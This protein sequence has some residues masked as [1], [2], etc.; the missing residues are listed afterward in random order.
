[1]SGPVSSDE[2]VE[3]PGHAAERHEVEIGVIPAPETPWRS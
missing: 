2:A 1:M 3:E